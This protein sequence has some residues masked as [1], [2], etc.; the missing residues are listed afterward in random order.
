MIKRHRYPEAPKP[1]LVRGPGGVCG[2]GPRASTAAKPGAAILTLARIGTPGVG[3]R[4]TFSELS[5]G[6]GALTGRALVALKWLHWGG[7][8]PHSMI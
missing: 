8:P 6:P 5:C 3:T 7:T 1:P 4:T 2:S